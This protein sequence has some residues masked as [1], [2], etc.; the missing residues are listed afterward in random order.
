MDEAN[1]I[2]VLN[3]FN[4]S[5]A[6]FLRILSHNTREKEKLFSLKSWAKSLENKKLW[7]KNNNKAM[8]NYAKQFL[9][10]KDKISI[11]DL[12]ISSFSMCQF[13]EK[14]YRL[15][16]YWHLYVKCHSCNKSN[17]ITKFYKKKSSFYTS[18]KQLIISIKV[19]LIILYP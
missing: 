18:L 19:Y 13:Y 17:Y 8:A 3:S 2:Q 9:K 7:M 4:F 5:F 11:I 15:D 16:K 1:K 14:R 10:K 12:A 6:Q